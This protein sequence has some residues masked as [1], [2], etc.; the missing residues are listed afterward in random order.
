MV[1][2]KLLLADI[3][4]AE[5]CCEVIEHSSQHRPTENHKIRE[6]HELIRGCGVFFFEDRVSLVVETCLAPF[7]CHRA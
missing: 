5:S 2:I 1:R 4:L 6:Q 3:E 7:N